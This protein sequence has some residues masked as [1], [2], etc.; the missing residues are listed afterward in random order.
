MI[1]PVEASLPVTPPGVGPFISTFSWITWSLRVI[2]TNFAL[3]LFWSPL[4][5]G[6][7]YSIT[8][9]CHSPGAF[10]AFSFGAAAP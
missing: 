1:G 3:A 8:N 6:A 2:F 10:D 4:K 7:V 5:R 9:F